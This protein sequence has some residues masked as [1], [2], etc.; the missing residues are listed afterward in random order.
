M[1][2]IETIKKEIEDY[3]KKAEYP[4]D[5]AD[6]YRISMLEHHYDNL[7]F[8]AKLLS[9]E[10]DTTSKLLKLKTINESEYAWCSTC[11]KMVHDSE[12]DW[13]DEI[14]YCPYCGIELEK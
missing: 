3:L 12:H 6:K 14:P 1:K 11:E 13:S 9:I 5:I 2:K 8:E 4:K 10:L 7:Y